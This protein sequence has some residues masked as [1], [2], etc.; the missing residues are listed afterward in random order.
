MQGGRGRGVWWS[1]YHSSVRVPDVSVCD[2]LVDKEA[3]V[4]APDVTDGNAVTVYR[5]QA[6]QR[7]FSGKIKY[8]REINNIHLHCYHDY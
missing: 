4:R 1:P 8:G 2:G 3:V 5:L 7:N 6:K